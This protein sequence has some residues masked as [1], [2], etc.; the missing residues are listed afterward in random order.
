MGSAPP[1]E[2]A[3][4]VVGRILGSVG[5]R[6]AVRAQLLTDFPENFERQTTL[7]VGDDLR[8]HR[9]ET[10]QLEGPTATIKLGGVDDATAAS[11]LRGQEISI[12]RSAAVTLDE[13]EFFWHQVIGMMVV[14]LSGEQIGPVVDILRTGANDVYIVRTATGDALIPAVESIVKSIDPG[15]NRLTIDPIPGL[16]D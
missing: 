11:A 16:L 7:F 14:T 6:G 8:P 1:G 2:P 9:V 12:P 15:T 10:C 4:L 13:G 3:F 5:L